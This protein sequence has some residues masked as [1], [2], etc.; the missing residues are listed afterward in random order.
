MVGWLPLPSSTSISPQAGQP[1][2]YRF[3]PMSQKAGHMPAPTGAVIGA[4][5]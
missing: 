5:T 4:S 1:A 2:L 3:W